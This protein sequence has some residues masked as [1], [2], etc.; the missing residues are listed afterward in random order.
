MTQIMH[1]KNYFFTKVSFAANPN[2]KAKG[3]A[4]GDAKVNV[5]S[6]RLVSKTDPL[7]FQ[8]MLKICSEEGGPY[9]FELSVV[10]LFRA[11]EMIPEKKR[12]LVIGVN[13]SSILYSAAR[14]YLAT[15]TGRGPWGPVLLPV[16]SFAPA[17]KEAAARQPGKLKTAKH[18]VTGNI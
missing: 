3:K 14:E 1:L 6:R 11:D 16:T 17:N 7:D 13:S 10:G 12:S 4:T 2:F 15:L 18:R 5:T 9:D 8:V